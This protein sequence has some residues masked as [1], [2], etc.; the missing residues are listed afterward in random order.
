MLVAADPFFNNIRAEVVA[1]ANAANYPAIYQWRTFV[2]AGGLMSYGPNLTKLYQHA[3]TMA[4]NLLKSNL[5][6]IPSVWEP[7]EKDFELFVNQ[8]T[9][10][11]IHLMWP[12]PPVAGKAEVI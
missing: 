4:G 2:D 7:E 3:G 11:K 5:R 12:L 8:A 10:K 9:A 1:H 6:T